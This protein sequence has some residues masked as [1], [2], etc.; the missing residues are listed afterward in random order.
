MWNH[1]E[2][3][4]IESRRKAE[5]KYYHQLF[6][7]KEGYGTGV[8]NKHYE[9]K[10]AKDHSLPPQQA[11]ILVNSGT[12]SSQ[13]YKSEVNKHKLVEFIVRAELLFSFTESDA[14][15]NYLKSV[16]APDYKRI[17]RQTITK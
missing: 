14:F 9:K 4:V 5:C 3:K 7:H 12:L 17:S 8:L 6:N 15:I 2:K 10:H 16:F 13:R 1:F 11:Q